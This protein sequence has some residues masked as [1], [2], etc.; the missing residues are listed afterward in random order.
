MVDEGGGIGGLS[1]VA[2]VEW[3]GIARSYSRKYCVDVIRFI[4]SRGYTKADRCHRISPI[5]SPA[6]LL[7][8]PSESA[9]SADLLDG[10]MLV[11]RNGSNERLQK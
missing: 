7:L 4:Y 8:L 3:M 11:Y 6:L 2:V 1:G 10:E 5:P 9:W